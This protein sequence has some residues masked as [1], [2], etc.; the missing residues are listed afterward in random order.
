MNDSDLRNMNEER[1]CGRLS[2]FFSSYLRNSQN[3]YPNQEKN[4]EEKGN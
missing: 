2:I 1:E 3:I 4:D